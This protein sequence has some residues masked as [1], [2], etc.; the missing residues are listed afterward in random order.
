MEILHKPQYVA[1]SKA[2]AQK[3]HH[4]CHTAE[5]RTVTETAT[6]G[7]SQTIQTDNIL[8]FP[9]D[10][11]Y[12]IGQINGCNGNHITDSLRREF[13]LTKVPLQVA[14][15]KKIRVSSYQQEI[16]FLGMD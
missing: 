9:L 14:Q 2:T 13:L 3:H 10:P 11:V 6:N 4:R 12:I 1:L 5:E 8:D 16:I 7:L 15:M